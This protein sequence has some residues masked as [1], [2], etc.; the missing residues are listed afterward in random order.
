MKKHFLSSF[1]VLSLAICTSC[2]VEK[3]EMMPTKPT[4]VETIKTIKV[5]AISLEEQVTQ[6]HKLGIVGEVEPVY[7]LPM[8][9]AILSRIDTGAATSSI[10][11]QNI[12]LFEREGVK[13]VSFDVVNKKNGERHH[14][15]KRVYR[16]TAIKRQKESEERIVVLMTIKM[17]DEKITT[18]FSLADRSKFDYQGLIGRNVLKGRAIVDTA[19]SKTLY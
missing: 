11:A 2:A 17:G 10:D 9:K 1:L 19:L 4:V 13:W 7:F 16:Q 14:F 18:Q 6:T 3:K 15:E 8:K 5:P 12:N